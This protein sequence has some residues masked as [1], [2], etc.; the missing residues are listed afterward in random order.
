MSFGVGAIFSMREILWLVLLAA[1]LVLNII[2]ARS[3][4]KYKTSKKSGIVLIVLGAG[5]FIVA[6]SILLLFK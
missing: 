2:G 5:I 1:S 6:A 4:H 3:L